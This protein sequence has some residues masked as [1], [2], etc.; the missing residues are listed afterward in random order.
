MTV[1]GLADS[2]TTWTWREIHAL[3]GSTYFGDIHC[4]TAWSKLDITFTPKVEN[5]EINGIEIIPAS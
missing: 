3:P 5:A 1:D 4:V 2:P